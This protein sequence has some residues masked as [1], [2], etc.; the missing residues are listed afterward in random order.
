LITIQSKQEQR[1][2]KEKNVTLII[3]ICNTDFINALF[4][5]SKIQDKA[6]YNTR[7]LM[8][9][10]NVQANWNLTVF[11]DLHNLSPNGSKH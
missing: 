8:P 5:F 3:G 4:K 11:P 9:L 2:L 10:I 1:S 7:I 6:P